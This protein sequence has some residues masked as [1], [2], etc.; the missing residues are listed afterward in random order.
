MLAGTLAGVLAIAKT[1]PA[2]G[3]ETIEAPEEELPAGWVR[4]AVEQASVCGTDLHIWSWDAWSRERIAPPRILGHEFCGTIVEVGAGVD[5]GRIGEFVASESHIVCGVCPQCR[6][7]LAHVCVRTRILG[8]DVDGGFRPRTILPS[9]NAVGTPRSIPREVAAFQDALGNAVHTV[10]DGPVEGCD[11]LVTGL[12]PIGLMA[13]AVAR[14]AGA[15]RVFATEVSPLR[16][17]LASSMG[18]DVLLPVE[19][20]AAEL[21]RLAPLGVDG[22]LEMSGHPSQLDLAIEATRPGGRVSCLGVFADPRP[23]VPMDAVIF[24]GLS[25]RGI[26]GRRLWET[27][28]RMQGLLASGLDVSPVVTHRLPYLDFARGMEEMAAGRAGKVVFT[29]EEPAAAIR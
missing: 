17:A 28:E 9:S 18:V 1:R 12:G 10:F 16:R 4:V 15:S 13:C 3:V 29:F 2:P 5:A 6:A 14:A 24:K 27:W 22:A 21:R 25:V 19:G 8:V 23:P 11:I 26:V 7:G 20:A